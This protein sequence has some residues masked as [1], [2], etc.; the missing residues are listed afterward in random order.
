[1]G[2]GWQ[3]MLTTLYLPLHISTWRQMVAIN[4]GRQ[5]NMILGMTSRNMLAFGILLSFGLLLS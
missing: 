2:Y 4:R 5:L 1:M 3:I